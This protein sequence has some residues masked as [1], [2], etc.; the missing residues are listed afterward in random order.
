MY[1]CMCLFIVAMCIMAF[2]IVNS[3]R[4]SQLIVNNGVYNGKFNHLFR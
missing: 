3:V 4:V 2:C 1:V